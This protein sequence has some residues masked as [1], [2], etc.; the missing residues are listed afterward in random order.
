M[1]FN[2]ELIAQCS[3]SCGGG[4]GHPLLIVAVFAGAWL[5]AHLAVKVL[6]KHDNNYNDA[7]EDKK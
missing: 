5:I 6:I 3:N 4:K 1:V 7:K 2:C